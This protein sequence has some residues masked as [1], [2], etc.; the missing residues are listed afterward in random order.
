MNGNTH[1]NLTVRDL[2]TSARW[3]CRVL[4]FAAV[5][6]AAP[7]GSGF[8]FR[9]LIH[10]GSLSSVVLG[11]VEPGP[12]EPG[13]AEPGPH[14]QVGP[15]E[16]GGAE[17]AR[18]VFDERRIGLHHLAYHV[19]DRADLEVWA[20][21]LDGERVAHSGVRELYLE[22]GYGI[23]LRDPDNIWLELYWLNANFFMDRLR[24]QRRDRREAV[25]P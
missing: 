20:A 19:P 6:D 14:L 8:R 17:P 11:Q 4:G 21:H 13:P 18:D 24:R 2:D 23:W 22:A 9:T 7:P 5:R 15:A 10:G 16:P 1:V 25:A 12:A 3:Y